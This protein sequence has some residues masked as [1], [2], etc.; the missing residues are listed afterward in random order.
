R[1]D[2]V[3]ALPGSEIATRPRRLLLF[4]VALSSSGPIG[5][6]GGNPVGSGYDAGFAETS[7]DRFIDTASV[8]DTADGGTSG[9]PEVHTPR[10]AG[11]DGGGEVADGGG[12]VSDGADAT[13]SGGD[14]AHE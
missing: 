5:A 2:S 8:A 4:A 7:R 6:C 11:G 12:E 1:H 3:D 10:G 14:G 13:D 9:W